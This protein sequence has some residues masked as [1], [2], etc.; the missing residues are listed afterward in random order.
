MTQQDRKTGKLNKYWI[1]VILVSV[2]LTGIGIYQ[3]IQSNQDVD[4]G[5]SQTTATIR[6]GDI[7]L[8]AIGSGTLISA[9]EVELSFEN[10][11]VVEEILVDV[12][13]EVSEGQLLVILDDEDFQ[14]KLDIAEST[15]RE[16]TSDAALAAAALELAEAQKAVLNAEAELKFLISPYVFKAEIRLREAELELQNAIHNSSDEADS[17]VVEAE[18]AAEDAA[19]SLALNWQIY[20]EEYVPVFFNFPWRDRFGFK[21]NYYDPPSETEIAL[22]WAELAAAEAKV[23]EGEAYLAALMEG[24]V[25]E[26]AYGTQLTALEKAGKAV[27]DALEEMESSRLVAPISGVVMELDLQVL[28]KVDTNPILTIAQLEPPTIEVSF[29]ESDWRLVMEGNPVEVIF[30]SLP[31]KS[32]NGQIVFVDPSLKISQK[33]TVVSAKVELDISS[34]EWVGLPLG[35]AASVE[36]IAGEVNKVVLLP[37]E[38]LQDQQGTWGTVLVLEKGEIT[39]QSVELGLRDVIYVEVIGGLS[40]GDVVVIGYLEK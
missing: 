11:G 7:R 9:V 18:H 19:I 10:R 2:V 38:A 17:R 26:N 13:D 33:T 30:D 12:G 8:S 27:D 39:Q 16:L 14:E 21:H 23:E 32:Y 29:S 3:L 15:L 25:P 36:V 28:D 22:T 24:V 6:R 20:E 37:V 35:S 1:F 34:T 40:A 5:I 4:S 31:E